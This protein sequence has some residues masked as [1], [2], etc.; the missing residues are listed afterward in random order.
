MLEAI[1]NDLRML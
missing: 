1:G